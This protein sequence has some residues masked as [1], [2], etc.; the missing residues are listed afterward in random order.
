MLFLGL[1]AASQGADDVSRWLTG[2]KAIAGATR[3]T[4]NPGD[5]LG[6]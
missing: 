5:R 6:D 2:D 1:S 4:R 3:P